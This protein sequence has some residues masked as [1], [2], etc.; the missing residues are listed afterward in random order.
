M[1]FHS[2]DASHPGTFLALRSPHCQK[3]WPQ[4]RAGLGSEPMA[5]CS[6]CRPKPPFQGL[7]SPAQPVPP[8]KQRRPWPLVSPFTFHPCGVQRGLLRVPGAVSRR[9]RVS[10]PEPGFC[11]APSGTPLPSPS[12]PRCPH[13]VPESLRGVRSQAHSQT[14]GRGRDGPRESAQGSA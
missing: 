9:A 14:E 8:S 10:L 2:M 7:G 11:E 12:C 1:L 6:G 13:P 4:R 3:A 5:F